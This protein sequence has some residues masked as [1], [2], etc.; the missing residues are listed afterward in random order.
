MLL[1]EK[2]F[3]GRV[4]TIPR[5]ADSGRAALSH[6]QNRLWLTEQLEPGTSLYNDCVA[7]RLRGG[8]LDVAV[9]DRVLQ[10]VVRRHEILRTTF[11]ESGRGP[12][13]VIH[14]GMRLPLLQEDLRRLPAGE[15]DRGF[16]RILEQL[17]APFDL[18]VLP[19]LRAALV[20]VSDDEHVFAVCMHHIISDGVSYGILYTELSALYP[21]FARGDSSHCR[22]CRSSSLT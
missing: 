15:V 2:G 11:E 19:L 12:I 5:R 13:Q 22:S 16:Q 7:V 18:T 3:A 20:R 8:P 14:P 9:F 4:A 21:A 10:E 6:D 1:S 17:Q